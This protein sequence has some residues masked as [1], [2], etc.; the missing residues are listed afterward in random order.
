MTIRDIIALVDNVEPNSYEDEL[1]MA[2]L[3]ELEG[4]IY[5]EVIKKHEGVLPEKC[6]AFS[7]NMLTGNEQMLV[8]FPYGKELYSHYLQMCIAEKNAEMDKYNV[9]AALF[10]SAY[11]R[12]TAWYT[13]NHMPK[14]KASYFKF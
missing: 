3:V 13:R 7:P 10:N 8:P 5:E 1:K 6:F 12:Y 4:Q 14:A 2:W 9:Q 11:D